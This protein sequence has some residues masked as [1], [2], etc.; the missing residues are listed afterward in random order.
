LSLS[1]LERIHKDAVT[2]VHLVYDE[3]T[4]VQK[5]VTTSMDGFIK[6]LDPKDA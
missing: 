2:S 6:M 1:K 3:E 4:K 5:V